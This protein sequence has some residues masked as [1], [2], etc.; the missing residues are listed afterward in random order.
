MDASADG[1]VV[2]SIDRRIVSV[3]PRMVEMWQVPP[4][5]IASGSDEHLVAWVA[6]QALDPGAFMAKADHLYDHPD[7]RSCDEVVLK[8]GFVFERYSAPVVGA[9]GARYCRVWFFRDVTARKEAEQRFRILVDGVKDYAVVLLDPKGQVASWNVGAERQFGYSRE[10]ILG[11]SI[12]VFYPGADQTRA[13]KNL[14]AAVANGRHEEEGWRLRSNGERFFADVVWN[15]LYDELGQPYGFAVVTRDITERRRMEDALRTSEERLRLALDASETGTWEYGLLNKRWMPDA[16]CLALFGLPTARAQPYTLEDALARIHPDDREQARSIFD[17]AVASAGSYKQEYRVVSD[18]A[19]DERWLESAG[20]VLFD[21]GKPHRMLGVVHDVTARHRYDEFRKLLPGIIAHD[22]R[23]PLSTIKMAGTMIERSSDPSSSARR[24]AETMLRGAEQIGRM[25]DRLLDFTQARFGGGLPLARAPMDLAEVCSE[26]IDEVGIASAEGEVALE[27]D[28]DTR[29][30][31]DRT[32]LSEVVSNLIGNAIKHGP[33]GEPIDVIVR[34]DGDHVVLSIH[35]GG[36]PIPADLLP[37]LFAPF[38]RAD[39]TD[40]RRG[41]QKSYGLGLYI[42]HEIVVAHCGTIEVRSST[43]QGTT[44]T[45]RLPR[46][47]L[48][49]GYAGSLHSP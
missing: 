5:V 44:F 15:P 17:E 38:S 25:A 7:E 40:R 41:A 14:E 9:D 34:G 46:G 4:D 26:M 22:L 42:S 24:Y 12:A 20:K 33:A 49:T 36:A 18:N 2:V 21:G 32:R 6:D 11:Q 23:S 47:A 19:G 16:R 37:V 29:G 28:G 8:N 31:W 1:I 10:Q 45:V 27:V 35:N 39:R 43:T 3:N 48:A 13:R 30:V